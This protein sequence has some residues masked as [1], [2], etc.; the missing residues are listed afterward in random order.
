MKKSKQQKLILSGS[1]NLEFM[2]LAQ[3]YNKNLESLLSRNLSVEMPVLDFGAGAGEFAVRLSRLGFSVKTLEIER[4]LAMKLQNLGFENT[5]TLTEIQDLSYSQ[6]YSLNVLEHI[7]NDEEAI[8]QLYSKLKSDGTLILYVPAFPILYSEM[9]KRVGHF[10]R[11]TKENLRDKL[12][13]NGFEIQVLHHVDFLG[14]IATIFYKLIPNKN[15][16]ISF[17]TIKFYD[18]FIFPLNAIFDKLFSRYCGKNLFVI[19]RKLH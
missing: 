4:S 18:I 17:A 10:R 13:Q 11:Y 1:V 8:G 15:G 12:V 19:A 5:E 6:I 16:S 2:R 7:E 9:D 14:F 3:N